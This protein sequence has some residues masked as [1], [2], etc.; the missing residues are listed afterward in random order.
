[1]EHLRISED[2]NPNYLAKIVKLEGL[3][4]HSNADKL[5]CITI[6]GN[7]VIT[8]L[9]AKEGDIYVFFPLEC[10]INKEFL[11]WSN[12]FEDKTLN[13]DPEKKGFFNYKGR[14]RALKLRGERSEGYIIPVTILE[15]WLEDIKLNKIAF[16][17]WQDFRDVINKEFD[18]FGDVKICEKYTVPVRNSGTGPKEK[19]SNHSFI[20]P[21]QFR[22]HEDTEKFAKNL[23]KVEPGSLISI[24]YKLHGTSFVSSNILC[25]K[26]LNWIEKILLF[27]GI[28][29]QK[30]EYR[31]IYSSRKVIKNDTENKIQNHYYGYDL[32]KEINE[33][34]KHALGEGISIYGEAVGYLKDGKII[35]KGYDYGCKT[36]EFEVYV[37]KVTYTNPEG[38]VMKFSWDQVKRFCR[39]QG[40]KHVPEIYYGKAWAYNVGSDFVDNGVASLLNRF[41]KDYE[42]KDCY[43][44]KTKVPT[45][46]VVIAIDN[47]EPFKYKT[48]AFLERE[49]KELDSEEVDLESIESQN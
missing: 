34:V 15:D 1:M 4:K 13:K 6:D 36:N 45:E 5:Q 39:E 22:F 38:R 9:D 17:L 8:G 26:S 48:F 16:S 7:N 41:E 20:V 47:G 14:V 28:N 35:Q 19:K 25:V 40:L 42:G 3:R 18:Y 23:E 43:M 21:G 30:T 2:A 44:C 37:Y 24:T 33:R 31:N 46:G 32:W 10:V 11:S 27:F 12:S 29:I 49:S